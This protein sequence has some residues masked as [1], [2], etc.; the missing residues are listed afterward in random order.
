MKNKKVTMLV[1]KTRF[2]LLTF[3]VVWLFVWAVIALLLG[4]RSVVSNER[5]D[6]V[7]VFKMTP[8]IAFLLPALL[9]FI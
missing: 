9:G 3:P 7:F 1:K 5:M 8:A 4:L 2:L 6:W